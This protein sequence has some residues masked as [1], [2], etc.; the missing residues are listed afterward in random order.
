MRPKTATQT[1]A[2]LTKGC[3]CSRATTAPVGVLR[4]LRELRKFP[5]ARV[6]DLSPIGP[7][8]GPHPYV[9]RPSSAAIPPAPCP[10]SGLAFVPHR[11][12]GPGRRGEHLRVR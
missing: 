3:E 11:G 8:A 6:V 9:F 12:F 4:E 10:R 5:N 7:E 2:T 1:C